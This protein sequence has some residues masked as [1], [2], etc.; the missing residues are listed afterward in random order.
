MAN[1][2]SFSFLRTDLLKLHDILRSL[3]VL[4]TFIYDVKLWLSIVVVSNESFFFFL[5]MQSL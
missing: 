1:Q 4:I 3:N 2:E 5:M